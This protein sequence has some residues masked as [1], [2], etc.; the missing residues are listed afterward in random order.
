MTRRMFQLLV[1]GLMLIGISSCKEEK[2]SNDII[3]K[4]VPKPKVP[5]GP[6]RLSDFLYEKKVKWLGG[7]FMIRIR[8]FADK[9]LVMVHDEDGREYYD[10]KILLQVLRQD[11]S[12]FY[13][14]TFT[15]DDFR[16]C[17][18]SQYGRDGALVG[19]MFDRAEGKTL[20]FGASVG[21]PDPNS[22]EYV[23][24][25]V[26]LDNMSHLRI[27][28]ATQLDTP[29][30]QPLPEKQKTEVEMSEEEGV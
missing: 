30:D 26:T 5:S 1:M 7:T 20:Y 10:N 2:K 6:Q 9:S 16:E 18:D 29:G 22:D 15:K 28:K 13:D 8:R 11:G 3:T 12:L 24:M 19:F 21:S 25:D 4:I 23:P 14:R 17:A 27:T